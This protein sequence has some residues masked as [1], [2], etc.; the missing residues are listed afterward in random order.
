MYSL[1]YGNDQVKVRQE[2]HSYA[3]SILEEDQILIKIEGG[4]YED[5]QL[6]SL[7][8]GMVL[9]GLPP[10][11][12]LDTPSIDSLFYEELLLS[13][14]SLASSAQTFVIIENSLTA[15]D[16]KVFE[17][18]AEKI[19]EFKKTATD[20]FNAFSM[21]DALSRKDKRL[22]WVLFQEAKRNKLA[23]EEIIGVLW[24]QLKTM[25]L[26][27]LTKTATEAGIKDFPYNKAKRALSNFKEG[28]LENI[29]AKLLQLYHDGH[30]GRRDIDLALE[31]WMLT[32]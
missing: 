13:L 1:F 21:A 17:K 31:E 20:R 9:F 7:S 27:K 11:Y 25:R 2:A 28:E 22:L 30:A 10:V 14:E 3:E 6:S 5:G 26:A 32:I 18:F 16:K 29:S 24:W 4:T 8:N 15:K 23:T 12:L 19:S